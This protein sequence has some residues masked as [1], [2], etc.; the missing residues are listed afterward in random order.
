MGDGSRQVG[1]GRGWRKQVG[2]RVDWFV[3][4]VDAG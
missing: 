3:L 2:I 4:R 1:C